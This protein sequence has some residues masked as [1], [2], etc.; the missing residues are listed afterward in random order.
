MAKF[1]W[2]LAGGRSS[3]WALAMY[4]RSAAG[5]RWSSRRP[6]AWIRR[7]CSALMISVS[8]TTGLLGVNSMPNLARSRSVVHSPPWLPGAPVTEPHSKAAAWN[9]TRD[10]ISRRSTS[11]NGSPVTRSMTHDRTK[12][13]T[14]TYS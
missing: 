13:L 12:A 1:H 3:P 14:L 9:S 10:Q 7:W 8:A 4:S 11:A 2:R 5:R 6:P